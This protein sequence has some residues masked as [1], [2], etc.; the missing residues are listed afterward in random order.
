MPHLNKVMTHSAW[1]QEYL[2]HA[3]A[4]TH[5]AAGHFTLEM[6]RCA[7]TLSLDEI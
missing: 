1:K 4:D 7:D 3:N 2:D 6:L 5:R